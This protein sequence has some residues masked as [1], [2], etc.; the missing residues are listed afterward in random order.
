MKSHQGIF[1][2]QMAMDKRKMVMEKNKLWNLIQ[3]C[4]SGITKS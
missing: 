3:S 2:V 1:K 4:N